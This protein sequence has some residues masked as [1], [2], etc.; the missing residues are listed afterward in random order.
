MFECL[1]QRYESAVP[2]SRGSGSGCSRPGSAISPL[3]GG[4]HY[5]HNRAARTYTRLGKQTLGEHK[6]NLLHTRNKEKGA[7]MP[8]ETDSDLPVNVQESSK[9]V[10]VSDGLLQGQS[11]ECGS[12]CTGPLEGGHHYLHSVQFSH[13]LVSNTLEPHRLQHDR[14]PCL[15]PTPRVYSNSCPFI[16][17]RPLLLLPSIFPSITVFSNESVLYIRWTKS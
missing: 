11:I 17:C 14:S 6:Q 7:V 2:S 8:K 1:L 10:W 12:A 3:G 13:S 5:P 4:H 15:S 9:E 16:L